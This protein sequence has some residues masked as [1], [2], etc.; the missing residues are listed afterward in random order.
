MNTDMVKT[1]ILS[2]LAM[3]I[4]IGLAG[5]VLL[6]FK[7]LSVKYLRYLLP[8][9]P[10][11]VAAYVF[12]YNLFRTYEG[13]LPTSTIVVKEILWASLISF[14]VYIIFV[15]LIVAIVHYAKD[16]F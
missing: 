9:P 15:C 7:E 14:L 12:V 3:G 6:I 16:I 5:V 2:M 10:I 8:I 11:G 4:V 13:R 1:T